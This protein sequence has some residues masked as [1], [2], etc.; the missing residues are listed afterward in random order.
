MTSPKRVKAIIFDCD[1]VLIDTIRPHYAIVT[2]YVNARGVPY[3]TDEMIA[4]Y[5]GAILKD[6][7]AVLAQEFDMPNEPEFHDIIVKAELDYDTNVGL[8]ATPGVVEFFRAL[9]MPK[10]IASNT[11]TNRLAEH[12]SHYGWEKDFDHVLGADMVAKP[13]PAPD[14]YTLAIEKL[15]V[16]PEECLVVEDSHTGVQAA[17]AA[18]ALVAGYT[19][20]YPNKPE[21]AALLKQHG[22]TYVADDYHSLH[23]WMMSL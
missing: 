22:A 1:G 6:I 23:R 7:L 5:S 18:G 20:V 8:E 3:S 15:G 17:H 21:R 19:G 2:E 13:K 10:A 12:I 11:L 14:L 4:R 9:S 16:A